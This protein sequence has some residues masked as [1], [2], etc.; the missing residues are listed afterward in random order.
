MVRFNDKNINLLIWKIFTIFSKNIIETFQQCFQQFKNSCVNI[1]LF[2]W[3]IPSICKR[4]FQCYLN[5]RILS[6][7]PRRRFPWQ[8]FYISEFLFQ[9]IIILHDTIVLKLRC[10]EL[11]QLENTPRLIEWIN[12]GIYEYIGAK[13]RQLSKI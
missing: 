1:A 12:L 3:N 9:L 7:S 10:L 13:M 6:L 8:H 2:Q 4:I 5:D 11:M